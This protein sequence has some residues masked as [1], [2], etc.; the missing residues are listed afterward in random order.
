MGLD[1]PLAR[2]PRCRARVGSDSWA[3]RVERIR[4]QRQLH[5]AHGL[6]ICPRGGSFGVRHVGP[7]ALD[8]PRVASPTA[9]AMLADFAP[10]DSL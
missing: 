7:R 3:E 1:G 4:P 10:E 5:G 8:W 9:C 6:R 2:G